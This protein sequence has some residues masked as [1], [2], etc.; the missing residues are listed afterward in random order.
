MLKQWFAMS[1][2]HMEEL[3]THGQTYT[4]SLT[5]LPTLWHYP[6]VALLYI[7]LPPIWLKIKKQKSWLPKI[8]YKVLLDSTK[9]KQ[10]SI[11]GVQTW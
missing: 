4:D 10:G 8:R 5:H 6:N 9:A 1:W 2:E 11:I 7:K 3:K